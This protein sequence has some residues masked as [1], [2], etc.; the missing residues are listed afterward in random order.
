LHLWF[1]ELFGC[2]VG[3]YGCFGILMG[4]QPVDDLVDKGDSA[5]LLVESNGICGDGWLTL[6]D[7]FLRCLE[8]I[9]EGWPGLVGLQKWLIR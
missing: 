3:G 6:F 7:R 5:R 9:F 8:V 4:G 1:G 2:G